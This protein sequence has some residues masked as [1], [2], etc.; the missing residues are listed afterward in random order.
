MFVKS[1][2]GPQQLA[3][4]LFPMLSAFGGKLRQGSVSEIPLGQS[5]EL[6][7]L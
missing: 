4:G 2:T 5:E 6:I 7:N 3:V 1:G